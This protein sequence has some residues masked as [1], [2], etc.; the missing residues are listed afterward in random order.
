MPRSTGTPTPTVSALLRRLER[1]WSRFDDLRRLLPRGASPRGA[2]LFAKRLGRRPPPDLLRILAWHDGSGDR[3]VDGYQRLLSLKG[4][5]EAKKT[6]DDLVSQFEETWRPGEWW[7]PGWLPFLAFEGDLLCVDLDGTLGEPAGQ[8]LSFRTHDAAR[9][10]LH[11]SVREWLHTVTVLWEELPDDASPEARP[12]LF[13]SK[14]AERIRRRLNPGYP[15]ARVA[16]K[17][18]APAAPRGLVHVRQTFERGRLQWRIDR[19][20]A[21]V[22]TYAQRGYSGRYTWKPFPDEE[23]AARFEEREVRAKLRAGYTRV[24]EGKGVR[25]TEFLAAAGKHAASLGRGKR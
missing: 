23:A 6:L 20:G 10:R 16:R 21:M 22:R 13:S 17:R 2:A 7:N 19:A 14:T 12:E 18:A 25:D 4:I 8:V 24:A 11:R 9:T 5:L 15:A 1:A 3:A